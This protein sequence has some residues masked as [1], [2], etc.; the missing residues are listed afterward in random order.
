[1]PKVSEESLQDVMNVVR[2]AYEPSA[3]DQH[4]V[5]KA[6]IAA[7]LLPAATA[8]GKGVASFTVIKGVGATL[9]AI[10]LGTGVYLGVRGH[11]DTDA[12]PSNTTVAPLLH[13]RIP[14]TGDQPVVPGSVSDTEATDA[15]ATDI[16]DTAN[17][18]AETTLPPPVAQSADSATV[19]FSKR[20]RVKRSSDSP[21]PASAN[22]LA[23]EIRLVSD[24]A[25]AINAGRNTRAQKLLRTHRERFPEGVMAQE[26]N[27]L[28]I[29]ALCKQGKQAA[30]ESRYKTFKKHSP[31]APILLRIK[32]VCAFH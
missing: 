14:F 10:V 26:R 28:E 9:L 29:I 11:A 5:Y 24:A 23:E 27:G 25:A 17:A 4:R 3:E 31:T 13:E 18:K 12:H 21:S 1:M 22:P 19:T 30:A 16:T 20:P 7:P 15:Q 6:V 32:S 2:A 8:I